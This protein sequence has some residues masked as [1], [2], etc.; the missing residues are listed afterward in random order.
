MGTAVSADQILRARLRSQLISHHLPVVERG[1]AGVRQ[2]NGTDVL[3]AASRLLAL[4]AQ[5][6]PQAVWGLGLRAAVGHRDNV[7]AALAD[8]SIVRT[9]PLRGTLHLMPARDL[10][11]VLGLTA[12]RGLAAA[13][14]RFH[15]L[16]L[17]P[18]TFARA[19][20]VARA[21]LAGTGGL[22]RDAFLAAL[23][24]AGVPVEGQ[25]G[26]HIIYFLSHQRLVC[27]G[28]PLG[29]QQ[30]LVLVDEWIPADDNSVP[31]PAVDRDGAL[32]ALALR[33]FTG[34][35]PATLK[36]LA[37]WAKITVA[38]AKTALAGAR[39]RLIEREL[40]GRAYWSTADPEE[41]TGPGVDP[42]VDPAAGAFLLPGFDEYLLGYQD[43]SLALPAEDFERVVPG[44][45]GIFLPIVVVNGRVV[46]T[47]RRAAALT[48]TT[49]D[50]NPF[51]VD[52]FRPSEPGFS[53]ALRG[54]HK[55]Y[56]RFHSKGGEDDGGELR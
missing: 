22:S 25:R 5:D 4:Q 55:N 11:W 47:W 56:A 15:E 39:E 26:Y 6:F 40:D 10:R 18:H 49:A 12:P 35:G 32:A 51:A 43:R 29:N 1:R 28:P 34:H 52:T 27:W 36:D 13:A 50:G 37:W 54:S 3:D 8:G 44:K 21:V 38:D 46:A 45:N 19:G 41:G 16:G 31:D 48:A 20:D 7:L 24:V 14:G 30:A 2:A 23:N 9:A 33:Y 42:A 17:D 53:A